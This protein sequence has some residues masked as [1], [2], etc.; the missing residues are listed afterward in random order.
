MSFQ[1]FHR[2]GEKSYDQLQDIVR[3]THYP[4]SFLTKGAVES[5]ETAFNETFE[6]TM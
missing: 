1:K 6:G 2:W 5:G 4:A 3:G